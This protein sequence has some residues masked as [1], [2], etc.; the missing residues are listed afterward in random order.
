M[1]RGALEIKT[2]PGLKAVVLRVT[3]PN[4]EFAAENVQE[5]FAFVRI[6]FTT[7][8]ARLYAEQMRLHRGVAPCKEF[9]THA[10]IGLQNFSLHGPNQPR[11]FAGR[12]EERKN[13]RAIEPRNPAKRS[14]RGT[15]LSGF[16]LTEDADRDPCGA[17]HLRKGESPTRPQPPKPLARKRNGFG[18]QSD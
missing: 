16:Q 1:R 11:I 12:F 15:H 13:V 14:Y 17:R 9:H 10:R 6:R 7:A 3:Q 8:A 4:F 5:F 2:I 18:R